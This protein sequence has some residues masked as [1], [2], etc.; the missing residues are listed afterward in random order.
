MI[1]ATMDRSEAIELSDSDSN[2][3][4]VLWKRVYIIGTFE[5]I[6]KFLWMEI[7]A[8]FE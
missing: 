6:G 1:R 3:H 8:G 7:G 5:E 4:V 2:L